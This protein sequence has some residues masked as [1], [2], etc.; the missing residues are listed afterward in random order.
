[1]LIYIDPWLYGE[2]DKTE[3]RCNVYKHSLLDIVKEEIQKYADAFQAIA[4]V[5][6][7]SDLA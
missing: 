2:S 3:I 5:S 7:A 4:V 1:M 6:I